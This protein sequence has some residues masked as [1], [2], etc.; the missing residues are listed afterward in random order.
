V[1]EMPTRP[2]IWFYQLERSSVEDTLP[3]LLEKCLQRGWKVLVN[4][5]S[6]ERVKALDAWLWTY[7]A[8]AWLPHGCVEDEAPDHAGEQPVLLASAAKH[9]VNAAQALFLLDGASRF[10]DL[11]QVA[12]IFVLFSSQDDAALTKARADWKS[13]KADG[14]DQSYWRQDE[15]GKWIKQA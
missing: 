8:N 4:C 11:A 13:G 2:E 3:S 10:E 6:E 5:Q 15:G 14:F 9:N 1:S 12:R 7:Q